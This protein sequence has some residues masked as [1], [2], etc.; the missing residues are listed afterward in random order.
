MNFTSVVLFSWQLQD[1]LEKD[2]NFVVPEVN[3]LHETEEPSRV[4]S[5]YVLGRLSGE[6]RMGNP[7]NDTEKQKMD[8]KEDFLSDSFAEL[9]KFMNGYQVPKSVRS[10][11]HKDVPSQYS[12]GKNK[13]PDE[14]DTGSD[15]NYLGKYSSSNAH[16]GAVSYGE[17]S[18]DLK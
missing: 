5:T 9:D 14:T 16:F 8:L 13:A 12:V 1:D 15:F 11:I 17:Q 7:S 18:E 2:S 10:E 4:G 3:I 6:P